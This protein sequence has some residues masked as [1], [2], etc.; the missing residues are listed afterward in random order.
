[1]LLKF[2]KNCVVQNTRNFEPF[3]KKKNKQT[4]KNVSVAEIIV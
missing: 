2:E 1:M 4:K 3:E